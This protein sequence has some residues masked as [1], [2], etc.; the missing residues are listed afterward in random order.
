MNH[1]FDEKIDRFKTP[2][3]KFHTG[4][5]KDMFGTD[6]LYPFWVA[7]QDFKTPPQIIAAFEDKIKEGIFGYEY[8]PK[9]FM[10]A[11][12]NWYKKRFNVTL[13]TD[14]VQ[15]TPTIMSSMSMALDLFTKTG[16][17]VIIQPPVYM[18]FENTL[19]RTGRTKITN[20][21]VLENL[22]YQMNLKEL[23]ELASQE[24]TKALMICN[25]HNPGGRVWT[26][27]ELQS[28]VDIC[29]KHHLLI[30]ADE[31]HADIVF[32]NGEFTSLLAFPEIHEQL[33][34]CYSPAK[35][36]NIASV[37]DSLAIIPNKEYRAAFS[38]LR[39]RY[40][41]GRT[42]AF[43]R[44]AM[45]IGFSQ[46]GEWVDELNHYL[47]ENKNYIATYL[48]ENIPQIKLVQQEGTYLVWLQVN[49]LPL[50]G[51]KLIQYLGQEAKMGL[52][53]GSNFGVSGK[54]F[55]RMNIACPLSVIK[56]AMHHLNKAVAKWDMNK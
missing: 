50:H 16:D 30:L 20:P 7:D 3:A 46:C 14:W 9:T 12:E 5:L 43:S 49:Q 39:I 11:L 44:I 6:D 23:E 18:E 26:K 33:I 40:N 21:L 34:V 37:T 17:G 45:E 4:Y 27:S 25:P 35:V 38:E 28:V 2:A 10:P 31:I 13:N 56:D 41:M 47:E 48:D 51:N 1:S 53:S 19:K 36:F 22:H 29:A 52:N 55:V 24:N 32:S 54:N 15:F 8:K 42:Y